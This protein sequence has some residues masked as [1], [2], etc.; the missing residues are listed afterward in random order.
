MRLHS[1]QP[2]PVGASRRG[3]TSYFVLVQA[4]EEPV[5]GLE[6]LA[7]LVNDGLWS[8]RP[9]TIVRNREVRSS[10]K[11]IH[12]LNI[13]MNDPDIPAHFGDVTFMSEKDTGGS[14]RTPAKYACMSESTCASTVKQLML[15]CWR[16]KTPSAI[17]SVS[18]S[19]QVC[20]RPRRLP[21]ARNRA[22]PRPPLRCM[23]LVHICAGPRLVA[24]ARGHAVQA[25]TERRGAVD[26]RVD[27]HW[28]D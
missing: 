13:K 7:R 17:L 9:E 24:R 20:E 15:D 19:A 2:R 8:V 4:S 1:S 16:M 23:Q 11:L 28:R 26:R 12:G 6:R 14:T 27:R 22:R 25:R 5:R 3:R 21:R 18:G 10:A